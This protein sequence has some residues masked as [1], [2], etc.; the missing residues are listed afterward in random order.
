MDF[1]EWEPIYTEILSSFSFS[2]SDDERSAQILASLV[3]YD[4]LPEARACI[5]SA[6]RVIVCGNAPCLL[7]DWHALSHA[8]IERRVV[9]AADGASLRLYAECVTPDIIVTDLDGICDA[10]ETIFSMNQNNTILVIHAHGDNIER[11]QSFVPLC[12]GP[13]ICTTQSQPFSHVHNVGGFSDG[14]RAVFFAHALGAKKVTLC[15][16]D[17]DDE[18]VEPMKREKLIWA[19]RLLGMLGYSV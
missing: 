2:R 6:E 9:I 3:H 4:A 18:E 15:G 1:T 13:I 17:L 10:K 12:P 19:R 11:I 8:E 16:F 14:D 5:S 7:D